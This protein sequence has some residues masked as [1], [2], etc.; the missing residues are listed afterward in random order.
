MCGVWISLNCTFPCVYLVRR[1]NRI[2]SCLRSS[3]GIRNMISYKAQVIRNLISY[4]D[5]EKQ[6]TSSARGTR[7]MFFC[8]IG[9]FG[10]SNNS[11][12]DLLIWCRR[13]FVPC[14]HGR[15]FWTHLRL[16]LHSNISRCISDFH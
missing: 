2:T 3:N 10:A 1:S 12:G 15:L 6:G 4:Q 11:T 8:H 14:R 9:R 5:I 7:L 16:L 13:V